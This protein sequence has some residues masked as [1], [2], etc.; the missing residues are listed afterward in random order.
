M[1]KISIETSFDSNSHDLGGVIFLDKPKN[2]T[3]EE[4]VIIMGGFAR[5]ATKE[6]LLLS[7]AET[8][9]LPAI[10][11][12]WHGLGMSQGAFSDVCAERLLIDL[13]K[14]VGF[15]MMKGFSRFHL[16]GHSFAACVIAL[17]TKD[18]CLNI[19]KKILIS[20]ALNQRF[21]LRYWFA[22]THGYPEPD[23]FFSTE[24]PH[25]K[26]FLANCK[27]QKIVKGIAI[28]PYYWQTE[29]KINYSH[30]LNGNKTLHIHGRD[31]DVVPLKSVATR[32]QETIIFDGANH[33]LAPREDNVAH[34][35][36]D[37]LA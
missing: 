36:T 31:D 29:M 12:D 28:N 24:W 6:K 7:I 11:F 27:E 3:P 4:I 1:K 18:P 21:L 33:Y 17:A 19:D 10:I 25:E 23:I 14:V 22:N 13:R 9:S 30:V 2:Q 35:I 15:L 37:F 16:T 8:I 34:A 26:A 32:F 20:P 5:V